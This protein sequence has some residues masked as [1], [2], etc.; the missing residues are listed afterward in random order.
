MAAFLIFFIIRK[1]EYHSFVRIER[2]KRYVDSNTE[3]Q[4]K[5]LVGC[6]VVWLG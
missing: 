5:H 1:R 4:F 6:K 2:K 3:P